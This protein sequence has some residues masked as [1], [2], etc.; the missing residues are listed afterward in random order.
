M[1]TIRIFVD[2]GRDDLLRWY[3]GEARHLIATAADG[4]RISLP[5]EVM[6]RFVS[7]DGL[8][9]WFLL[10]LD[11]DHRFVGLR[12]LGEPRTRRGAAA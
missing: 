12:R 9:G 1:S 7:G 11:A 3:R 2:V 5:V 8:Q 10:S 6:R 4:R